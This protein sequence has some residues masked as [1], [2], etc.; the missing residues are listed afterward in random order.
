MSNTRLGKSG[1]K[2]SKIVLGCMSYGSSKW[3]EWVLDEEEG[4]AL[5]EHAYKLGINTWDTVCLTTRPNHNN[6][7]TDYYKT[8]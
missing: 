1:L 4:L 2:I 3:Q 8:N 5:I 6:L 7:S